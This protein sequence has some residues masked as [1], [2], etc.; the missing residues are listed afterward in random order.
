VPLGAQRQR[1]QGRDRAEHLRGLCRWRLG[2]QTPV[3]HAHVLLYCAA[4]RGATIRGTLPRGTGLLHNELYVRRLICNVQRY[5]KDPR[6]GKRRARVNPQH[7]L[8]GRFGIYSLHV[9]F[10]AELALWG[11]YWTADFAR[12]GALGIACALFLILFVGLAFKPRARR[13]NASAASVGGYRSLVRVVYKRYR[14][15]RAVAACSSRSGD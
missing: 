10:L 15:S 9:A 4:D 8:V 5:V 6:S 12:V 7:D 14:S 3:E 11:G 13:R 2:A 1:R